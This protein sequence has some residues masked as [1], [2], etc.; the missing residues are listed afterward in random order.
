MW[1]SPEDHPIQ[2]YILAK[3]IRACIFLLDL[4]QKQSYLFFLNLLLDLNHRAEFSEKK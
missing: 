1:K 3:R 2:V 4:Q